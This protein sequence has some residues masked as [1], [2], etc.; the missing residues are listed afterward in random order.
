MNLKK[1]LVVA[2]LVLGA[3][4][5]S[6]CSSDSDSDNRFPIKIT[7]SRVATGEAVYSASCASCHGPVNGPVVLEGAP[8]HNETG[9]TW[10]HPDR[11]L[12]EWVMDRPPLAAV[13]PAF[14][15]ALSEDEVLAVIAYI[16]NYWPYDIQQRHWDGS[17]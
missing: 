8:I 12:F 17:A 16:K 2:S 3:V 15:G 5:L 7:D 4:L 14:R 11:L 6:G 13:M 10:H 1:M 9:H